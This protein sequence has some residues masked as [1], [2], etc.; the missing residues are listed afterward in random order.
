MRFGHLNFEGLKELG[1]KQMV[2]GLPY[3]NH[4]RQ[5]FL[6]GKHSRKPFPE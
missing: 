3:I 4:P 6:L 5:L 2:K 1:H